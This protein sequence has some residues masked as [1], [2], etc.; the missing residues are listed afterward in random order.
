MMMMMM[1]MMMM[2]HWNCFPIYSDTP[3]K[4]WGWTEQNWIHPTTKWWFVLLRVVE[5]LNRS[6]GYL[7]EKLLMYFVVIDVWDHVLSDI[8][9]NLVCAPFVLACISWDHPVCEEVSILHLL[10]H[11]SFKKIQTVGIEDSFGCT[12]E[13]IHSQQHNIICNKLGLKSFCPAQPVGL[14]FHARLIA[15]HTL[16]DQLDRL[17]GFVSSQVCV[18]KKDFSYIQ[19][20]M[21][22]P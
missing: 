11:V 20:K 14:L 8:Q 3:N 18:Q 15:H 13:G 12:N 10:A 16:V 6:M 17:V 4:N 22:F 2:I 1:M 9:L 7:Q 21:G 19:S 5:E